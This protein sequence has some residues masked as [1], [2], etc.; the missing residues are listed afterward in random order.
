M[1][2]LHAIDRYSAEEA[3]RHPWI[4]RQQTDIPLTYIERLNDFNQASRLRLL[5]LKLCSV[6]VWCRDPAK[7][8]Q[9]FNAVATA[10]APP[11]P[12]TQLKVV[13]SR[14]EGGHKRTDS[15]VQAKSANSTPEPSPRGLQPQ[16]SFGRLGISPVTAS[17]GKKQQFVYR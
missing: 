14:V 2:S 6:S 3:L 10:K 1:A 13:I 7:L 17:P 9:Y 16:A 15:T 4:T 12:K 8:E 11:K 5:L